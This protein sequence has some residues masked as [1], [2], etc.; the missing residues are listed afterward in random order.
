MILKKEVNGLIETNSKL[1]SREW[2]LYR[3]LKDRGNQWTTQE[4]IAKDLHDIYPDIDFEK[5]FHDR[6]VRHEIGKDIRS[7]NDSGMIQKVILST[8]NGIKL[9]TE[10]EFDKYIGLQINSTL[11]RLK[12]LKK[13]AEK[14]SLDN[15]LKFILNGH[16]RPVVEAFLKEV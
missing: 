15:Q 2:H 3:Y 1:C 10:E 5:P 8:P 13:L 7:L 6:R 9:A 16:E 4:Q 14:G 12:R 11:N